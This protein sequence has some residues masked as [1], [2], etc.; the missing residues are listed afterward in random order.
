[1]TATHHRLFFAFAWALVVL[2]FTQTFLRG[3]MDHPLLAVAYPLIVTPFAFWHGALRYGWGRMI[4][5]F[6]MVFITGWVFESLSVATGFPFGHYHYT[7]TLGW[8]LGTVP[9]SVMPSYFAFGYISWTLASIILQRYDNKIIGSELLILP[10]IA[11]YIMSAW[12]LRID[13]LA[14]TIN[15]MWI[16]EEGGVF[17][18]VPI[19]NFLGWYFVVFLFYVMFAFYNR[20]L[21]DHPTPDIVNNQSYWLLAILIY[22]SQLLD[23]LTGYLWRENVMVTSL[24]GHD[25]WSHD[26]YGAMLLVALW[27]VLPI[28]AYSCLQLAKSFPAQ[29][30]KMSANT[31]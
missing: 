20:S 26:I 16:W 28:V 23:N 8:K 11:A 22:A 6:F 17:F 25:W 3:F 9:L 30:Q 10:L 19:T 5:F 18:G 1:M 2:Q 14:S 27:T 12:D 4:V 7:D 24:D 29:A 31:A 15:P 21:N 13:P